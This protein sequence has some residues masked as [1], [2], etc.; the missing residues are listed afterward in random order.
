MSALFNHDNLSSSISEFDQVFGTMKEWR[1]RATA[2]LC[3]ANLIVL[4][5]FAPNMF[6]KIWW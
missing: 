4:T 2:M 3:I 1:W 6:E 5:I